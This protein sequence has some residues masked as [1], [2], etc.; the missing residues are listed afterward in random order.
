MDGTKG[1]VQENRKKPDA[2]II[3]PPV[4]FSRNGKNFVMA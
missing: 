4:L 3:K 2:L 1:K